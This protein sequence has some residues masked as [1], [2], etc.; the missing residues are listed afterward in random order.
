MV[1]YE[2]SGKYIRCPNTSGIYHIIGQVG[3]YIR[4]PNSLAKYDVLR[5]VW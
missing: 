5:K 2:K 3:K 1:F 4:C